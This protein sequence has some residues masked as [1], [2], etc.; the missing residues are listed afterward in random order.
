MKVLLIIFICLAIAGLLWWI[1]SPSWKPV[2]IVVAAVLVG[3]YFVASSSI[4]IA[5]AKQGLLTFLPP[6]T[7]T[8]VDAIV[9]LGRGAETGEQRAEVAAQL[10]QAGRG[11]TI[12]L[13]GM[14]DAPA[15]MEFLRSKGIPSQRLS[16]ENCSQSTEENARFT[17]AVLQPRGV[18]QILLITDLPHMVRSFWEFSSLGVKVVPYPIPVPS[19]VN[20]SRLLFREYLGLIDYALRGKARLTSGSESQ[21]IPAE[22]LETL[23]AGNCRLEG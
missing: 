15:M 7:G 8:T 18:Q 22:L 21:S 17:V 4:G 10:W 23:T 3:G 11:P 9:V 5:L 6:D 12:F 2:V 14:R 20:E 16:G 13:S 1:S 19:Y